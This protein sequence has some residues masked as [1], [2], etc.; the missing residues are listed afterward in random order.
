MKHLVPIMV[1][2]IVVLSGLGAAAFSSKVDV[3]HTAD[4]M[5]E[6][7]SVRFL[8][9]PTMVEKDGFV[10][11]DIEG[12]T[13]EVLEQSRPVLPIYVKT[14]E[15]PFRSTDIQVVCQPQ[16]TRTV[17]LTKEVIPAYLAPVS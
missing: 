8:S 14:Y 12:A 15:I 11:I 9:Q 3:Q 7:A 1:I 4:V 6:S 17:T 13:S 2:G 10:E 5:T 16:A